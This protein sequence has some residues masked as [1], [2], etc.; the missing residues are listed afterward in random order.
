MSEF[1]YAAVKCWSS[2]FSARK[3]LRGAADG[4]INKNEEESEDDAVS[5]PAL[6]FETTE[7]VH[8]KRPAAQI[9]SQRMNASCKTMLACET[10]LKSNQC[11]LMTENWCK[12]RKTDNLPVQA[13]KR[14]HTHTLTDLWTRWR[15]Y[16]AIQAFVKLFSLTSRKHSFSSDE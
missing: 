6:W 3:R 11:W 8:H 1:W 15:C 14:T 2:S 12:S 5:P 7:F 13:I 4:I 16:E 9:A 10:N